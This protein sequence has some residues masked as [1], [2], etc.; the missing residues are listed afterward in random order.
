MSARSLDLVIA[1]GGLSGC[2]AALALA[3]RRPDVRFLLI[4]Q[5]LSFGGQHTWSFFDTDVA[6]E[7]RWLIEPLLGH[8]WARHDVYFPQRARTIELGYNSITSAQLD[9]LVRATLRTEQYRLGSRIAE[10]GE[11]HA[12]MEG[13]E[14]L[15]AQGVIDARGTGALPGIELAWQKFVGRTYECEAPH[16]L[17][18]PII[19]DA[20]VEQD[21]GY[22][23]LYTL[24]FSP[25]TLMVEDTY[26]STS[27][28]LDVPL[29]RSRIEGY[30]RR[31]AWAPARLL[32]EEK[33]VLPVALGG[34]LSQLWPT[35]EPALA[36]LGLRGGFFHPTT[37]Y[38]L[39]DAVR[40]AALLA[41]QTDLGTSALHALYRER[42][43]SL[44][45]ERSFY[46][47]LNRLLFRAAAPRHRFRVLQHFYR[48]PKP[49]IARFYAAR[50]TGFDKL[51]ILSGRPPVPIG[52]AISVLRGREA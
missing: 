24:P 9:R 33:G 8:H 25:M 44:W 18:R 23:F 5:G 46:R 14:R 3:M 22:R 26:Y 51:R 34:E 27:P 12:M 45:K 38:S 11:T 40:N 37:G 20:M 21:R 1:G 28:T 39:P 6:P 41:R 42:A 17:D 10:L 13:G 2:L 35:S 29:L 50:S 32:A 52:K 43:L 16:K 7:D 36:K 30:M 15:D 48:L 49:R 19:M 31:K 47:M 4:E